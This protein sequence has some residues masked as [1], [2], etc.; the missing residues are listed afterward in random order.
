MDCVKNKA[1]FNWDYSQ[2]KTN[3]IPRFQ[4][5]AAIQAGLNNSLK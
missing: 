5:S 1:G 2:D 3:C 4:M